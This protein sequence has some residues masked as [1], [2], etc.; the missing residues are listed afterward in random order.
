MK[1]NSTI[2]IYLIFILT[3][4]FLPLKSSMVYAGDDDTYKP[5]MKEIDK[6][7]LAKKRGIFNLNFD[8][9]VGLDFA[10]T[11]FDLNKI[12]STTSGLNS[13]TSKVGPAAGVILSVD[14]LGFGFTTGLLYSSKGFQQSNGTNFNL[15]FINI[16]LLFYFDIDIGKVIIDGNVGPYF[17]L[18]MS[19][20]NSPI[21]SI[22]K[23][24]FGLTGNVQGAYMISKYI[25]PLLGVKF[26]YGGLN[27]LGNNESINSIR[28][29]S[30]FVY[31]GVK[32]V[33]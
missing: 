10:N 2:S 28:T 30:F 21:Y 24:D 6:M 20:D 26:E 16:P 8:V 9:Q 4:T 11:K 18:L 31:T 33:L 5:F 14:F 27:N 29:T 23:F 22:K 15:N 19:T 32:F 12:D 25:G 3:L 17:G 1:I 7:K 13:T